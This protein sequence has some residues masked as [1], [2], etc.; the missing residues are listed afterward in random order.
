MATLNNSVSDLNEYAQLDNV[1]VSCNA[2]KEL[3][4]TIRDQ[5]EEL[6]NSWTQ[7]DLNNKITSCDI[8]L[9]IFLK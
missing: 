8:V 4:E 1:K 3:V 2:N 7:D 9:D 6:N 5:L